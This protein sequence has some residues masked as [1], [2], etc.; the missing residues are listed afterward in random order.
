[1]PVRRKTRIIA[2]LALAGVALPALAQESLLPPGFNDV[3]P[4]PEQQP[5]QNTSQ[6]ADSSAAAASR[7]AP[8]A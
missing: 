4:P 6:P 3:A 1:M 7:P 2:C 5:A 8:R